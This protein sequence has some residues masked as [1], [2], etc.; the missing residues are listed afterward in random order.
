MICSSAPWSCGR[1]IFTLNRAGPAS[2]CGCASMGCSALYIVLIGVYTVIGA[3]IF[4]RRSDDRMALVA[5]L[6]LVTIPAGL[7]SSELA[8]LP[9]AWWLPGQ[10]AAFLGDISFFLFFSLFPT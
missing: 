7:G 1:A 9:S 4:W 3:V 10:F 5:S 6:A 8:T 2:S